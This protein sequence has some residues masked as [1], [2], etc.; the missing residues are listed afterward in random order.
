MR[1]IPAMVDM[2]R[3]PEDW[4]S[5]ND[6]MAM[7]AGGSMPDYPK[8]YY[9]LTLALEGPE[10]KKLNLADEEICV[11]DMIHIHGMAVVTS[12]SKNQTETGER[13]RVELQLQHIA[14]E[15]ED[16]ENEEDEPKESVTSKLYS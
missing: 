7:P 9:G 2:A 6:N 16:E 5:V 10:I 15:D 14:A 11:G 4:G 12:I 3:T 13:C 1:V 8:Y